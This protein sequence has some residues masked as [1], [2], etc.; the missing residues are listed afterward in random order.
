MPKEIS[1][2]PPLTGIHIAESTDDQVCVGAQNSLL[3][4]H[5]L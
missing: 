5:L 4:S 2:P 1:E 3:D